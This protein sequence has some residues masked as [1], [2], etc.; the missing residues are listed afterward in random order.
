M[1]ADL[2]ETIR[3]LLIREIPIRNGE[4]D[5]KFDQ[6]KR[7]WSARLS[8]PTVNLFLYDIRENVTLRQHQM[9]MTRHNGHQVEQKRTPYRIDCV[10]MI[11]AWATES[12]DEH[13][14]IS[15]V[16][17]ALFRFPAL[18]GNRVVGKL[19]KQPFKI[20]THL[21]RH[22]KLTNPAEVWSAMDNELRPSISYTVTLAVDPWEA[23]VEPTVQIF[24]MQSQFSSSQGGKPLSP[25]QIAIRSIRISGTIRNK[26]NLPLA[27]IPVTLKGT[28][29]STLTDENGRYQLGSFPAGTYT[30]MIWPADTPPLERELTIPAGVSHQTLDMEI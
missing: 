21:A 14:L 25:E 11:T 6:P 20:S 7:E 13:R 12:E 30:L 23:V 29:F 10:Y 3:Q 5:V 17:H 24:T 16:L 9:E 15:R 27:G 28:T 26:T 19:K 4:I 8:K 1:L 22:D 2:D 18:P